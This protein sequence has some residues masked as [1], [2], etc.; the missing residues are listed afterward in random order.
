MAARDGTA[1]AA[2]TVDP[3]PLVSRE[4]PDPL[5]RR[6]RWV[7][8]G[9]LVPLVLVWPV[10]LVRPDLLDLVVPL[11]PPA[12]LVRRVGPVEPGPRV[13][14]TGLASSSDAGKRCDAPRFL[15]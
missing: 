9:P 15:I 6:V 2:R 10:P 7:P 8:L 1:G 13:R 11:G 14:D 5:V 12:P 3:G 4:H